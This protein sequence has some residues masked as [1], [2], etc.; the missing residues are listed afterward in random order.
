MAK[1]SKSARLSKVTIDPARIA[2]IANDIKSTFGAVDRAADDLIAARLSTTA[3]DKETVNVREATMLTLADM[4]FMGDWSE[5]EVAAGMRGALKLYTN[6]ETPKAVSTFA[7]E[8][9]MVMHPSVRSGLPAMI[10]TINLAWSAETADRAK[11]KDTP[12]P[13]RHAFKRKYHLII[14][15]VRA[16]LNT[17]ATYPT[18]DAL[19]A[20]AETLNPDLDAAKVHARLQSII[21]TL[22]DFHGDFPDADIEAC[23]GFLNGITPEHLATAAREKAGEAGD[24]VSATVAPVT[25]AARAFTAK[26]AAASAPLEADIMP[27]VV[28]I[29]FQMDYPPTVALAPSNQV[30]ACAA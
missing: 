21:G 27:G 5:G 16:Q 26:V 28:D 29:D 19:V 7:G 30:L 2:A 3:A 10:N 14:S 15:T 13:L 4:A 8:A 6:S 9:R 11:D 24:T 23:I 12:T 18:V 1:A 22:T 20:W 17:G 25:P